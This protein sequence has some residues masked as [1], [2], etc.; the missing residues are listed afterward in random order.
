M[1]WTPL[2]RAAYNGHASIVTALLAAGANLEAKDIVRGVGIGVE[3]VCSPVCI[4]YSYTLRFL[5]CLRPLACVL[6]NKMTPVEWAQSKGHAE[7]VALLQAAAAAPA[8]R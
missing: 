4:P 1:G 6:Q 7:V 2:H 8:R 3:L 5:R